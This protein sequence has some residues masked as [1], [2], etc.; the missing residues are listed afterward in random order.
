SG[1]VDRKAADAGDPGRAGPACEADAA[2]AG[3][4]RDDAAGPA[5]TAEAEAVR[6]GD[7]ET[8]RQGVREPHAGEG[9]EQWRGAAEIEGEGGGAAERNR[10]SAEI[11]E[12]NWLR[13]G[14]AGQSRR[15]EDG[16]QQSERPPAERTQNPSAVEHV[17]DSPQRITG[18]R[19]SALGARS[20]F[21]SVGAGWRPIRRR[22]VLAVAGRLLT[23]L[24]SLD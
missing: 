1:H 2:A 24:L 9:P 12:E 8:G 18:R 7:D 3:R 6:R 17:D 22:T 20:V 10:G 15:D 19:T 4:R 13:R 16:R 21:V 23:D 14:G 5:R 11:S